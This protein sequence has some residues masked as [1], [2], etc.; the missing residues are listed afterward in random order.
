MK[1]KAPRYDIKEKA[2]CDDTKEKAPRDDRVYYFIVMI[3]LKIVIN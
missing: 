2:P 1:E 3:N